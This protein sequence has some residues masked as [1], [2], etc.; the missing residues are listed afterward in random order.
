MKRVGWPIY[1]MAVSIIVTL[2]VLSFAIR[3]N[4]QY[5]QDI[6]QGIADR[7]SSLNQFLRAEVC[8][9]LELRDEIQLSYLRF[10]LGTLERGSQFHI[11]LEDAIYALEV[12]QKGC[13][14]GIPKG[15]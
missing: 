6:A 10:V 4:R 2:G 12:T 5:Q 3:A 9:R 11:V 14:A 8:D 15:G 7:N 1:V 13:A